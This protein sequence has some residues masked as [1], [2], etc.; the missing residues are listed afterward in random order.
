M[1]QI[2]AYAKDRTVKFNYTNLANFLPTW[3]R[4]MPW[5]RQSASQT[6]RQALKN[7]ELAYQNFFERR[8]RFPRFKKR[9]VSDSFRYPQGVRLDQGTSRIFPDLQMS[10]CR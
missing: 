1:E 2:A 5:L 6:L 7:L 4:E 8:A 3:K 10:T 9:G